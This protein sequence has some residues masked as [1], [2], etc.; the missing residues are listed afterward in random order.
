MKYYFYI[1]FSKS[2]NKYYIGHC[3]NIEERL[4]KH[5]T[6]HKGFTGKANDWVVEYQE[7]YDLK[8][9]AYSRERQIKKWKS[10]KRIENLIKKDKT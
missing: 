1:L 5:N 9:E 3:S 7:N 6:N 10:R 8:T 2:L 4:R